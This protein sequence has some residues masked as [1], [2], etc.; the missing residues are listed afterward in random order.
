M[1]IIRILDRDKAIE[2][3]ARL[4]AEWQEAAGDEPLTEV[5]APVGLFLLDVV[6]ALNLLPSE[7]ETI[8]DGEYEVETSAVMLDMYAKVD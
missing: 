6:S 3:L 5:Y 1:N 4:R 8:F 2:A 7:V